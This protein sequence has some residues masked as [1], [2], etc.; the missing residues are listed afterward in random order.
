MRSAFDCGP[1]V[2][3]GA[4]LSWSV[5]F[6]GNPAGGDVSVRRDKARSSIA[7][8]NFLVAD[9]KTDGSHL[10]CGFHFF[11]DGYSSAAVDVL[12]GWAEQLD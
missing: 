1:S 6:A 9:P 4:L 5:Q 7:F 8:I 2:A 10:G 11:E 3:H 12:R